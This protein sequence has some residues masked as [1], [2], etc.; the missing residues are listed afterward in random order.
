MASTVTVTNCLPG[1]AQGAASGAD[2]GAG[3]SATPPAA[4]AVAAAPGAA[5]PGAQGVPSGGIGVVIVDI[6][7]SLRT[8][9]QG[10]PG[11]TAAPAAPV[12]PP[13]ATA[14]VVQNPA[15]GGK[16]DFYL[17]Q[18]KRL[19]NMN[20]VRSHPCPALRTPVLALRCSRSQGLRALRLSSPFPGLLVPLVSSPSRELPTL[21]HLSNRF[22]ELPTLRHLSSLS[23]RLAARPLLFCLF[24]PPRP[25][26]PPP[27]MPRSNLSRPLTPPWSRLVESPE[28]LST[29]LAHST[30]L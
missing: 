17:G 12:Q 9:T 3:S 21:L 24:H 4:G 20:Q 10:G 1:Q 29:L 16:F 7:E 28:A 27:P 30:A 18:A 11:P 6:P 8:P 26:R 14:P 25:P 13:V 19:T 23:R 22:P 2:V 15:A 5:S